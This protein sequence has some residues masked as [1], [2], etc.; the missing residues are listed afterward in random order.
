M[1]KK[2]QKPNLVDPKPCF[3]VNTGPWYSVTTLVFDTWVTS[4]SMPVKVGYL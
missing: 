4:L 1:A 2:Y 3:I